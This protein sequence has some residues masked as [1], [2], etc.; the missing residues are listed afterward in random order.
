VAEAAGDSIYV[1][2]TAALKDFVLAD[3]AWQSGTISLIEEH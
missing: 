1:R 3:Y 2:I